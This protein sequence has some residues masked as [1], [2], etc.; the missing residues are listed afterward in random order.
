[1][2]SFDLTDEQKM[3][4]DSAGKLA[5]DHLRKA[6]READEFGTVMNITDSALQVLGGHGHIREHPVELWLRN[7]RGFATFDGLAVV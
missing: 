6:A 4:V 7:G 3:L 5:R 2:T 1:M